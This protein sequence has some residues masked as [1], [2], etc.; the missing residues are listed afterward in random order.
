MNVRA[1]YKE[2]WDNTSVLRKI[3]PDE[4]EPGIAYV[5]ASFRF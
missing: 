5:Q 3:S 2:F 1:G 4:Q